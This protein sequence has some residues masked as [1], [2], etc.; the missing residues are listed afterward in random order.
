MSTLTFGNKPSATASLSAVTALDECVRLPARAFA[1]R[2]VRT[3]RLIYRH[4]AIVSESDLREAVLERLGPV[5]A[6]GS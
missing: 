5:V 3:R 1:I 6:A 4:Y 2:L